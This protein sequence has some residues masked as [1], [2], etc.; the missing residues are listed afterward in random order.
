MVAATLFV[1]LVACD[2]GP[3]PQNGEGGAGAE[4]VESPSS[5][6]SVKQPAIDIEDPTSCKGCHGV[7]YRE[8]TESMHSRAHHEEDPIYGAMRAFRMEKQGEHIASS[9]ARCHNPRSPK[10]P[11]AA[12]GRAGVSCAACHNVAEVHVEEGKVGVE[13]ITWDGGGVMRSSRDLE[14]GASPVHG[15]GEA[16]SAMQDGETLCLSCHNATKTP[17]GVAAC[18]TGPEFREHGGEQTCVSCHM[19]EVEGAAGAVGRQERHASHQFLGPHRAWYQDDPSFLESGLDVSAA[20]VGDAL[21]VTLVNQSAHGFPS[22]FPGRLV[23]VKVVGEDAKGGA[24]WKNVTDMP[25]AEHPDSMLNKVYHDA[26]G[27]P[28]PAA[29]SVKLARDNRLKPDETRTITYAIPAN[30]RA[31]QVSVVYRLLPPKLAKVLGLAEREEATPR[32]IGTARA[33]R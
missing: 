31:V 19:P 9:C 33:R 5:G 25:M 11:D 18:T 3:T 1:L 28:V 10:A 8:W 15:T 26:E 14:P 21:E 20:F 6:A 29:F 27:E 13:T 24:V 22:G 23:I 4:T 17:R 2:K 32:V 16:L 12:A 7:I 30:V